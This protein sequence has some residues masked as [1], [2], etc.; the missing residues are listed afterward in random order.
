[1]ITPS[2][3][4]VHRT[5]PRP[6]RARWAPGPMVTSIQAHGRAGRFT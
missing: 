5:P 4:G 1:M 2:L 6:R 3:S